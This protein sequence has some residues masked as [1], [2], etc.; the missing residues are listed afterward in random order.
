VVAQ[1]PLQQARLVSALGQRHQAHGGDAQALEVG[2]GRRVG[3]AGVAPAQGLGHIGVQR[4]KGLEVHLV[5]DTA[6]RVHAGLQC[7]QRRRIG[8]HARFERRC[9][10]VARVGLLR[11][12]GYMPPV[13]VVA[14]VAAHHFAGIGVEQQL[15]GVEA[16]AVGRL[17]GAM[18]PPAI[19]RARSQPW[20]ETVPDAG[21]A[22]LQLALS[23]QRV[24]GG[25]EQAQG[26]R[27]G[28]RRGQRE[29]NASWLDGGSK[30]RRRAHV[31]VGS[32]N[33]SSCRR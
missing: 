8:Q 26:D 25:A 28:V 1:A 33:R 27:L 21:V 13:D 6:S 17:P 5:Q 20:L 12:V 3:E 31:R 32:V 4:G 15:G 10:V 19:Q 16:V 22:T 7:A 11:V 9:G 23:D 29:A 14:V 30:L 2:D 24:I 18:H